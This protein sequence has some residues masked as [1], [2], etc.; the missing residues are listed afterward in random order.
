MAQPI[1]IPDVLA[2]LDA[3]LDLDREDHA[4]YE[5]G[6]KEPTSYAGLMKE[7]ARIRGLRRFIIPVPVLTAH[8]SSHWLNLVTPVYSRIGRRLIDSLTTPTVVR[9]E[10]A[11]RD[12]DVHPMGVREA[13]DQAR[14]EEEQENVETHWADALSSV[15]GRKHWGGVVFGNR[16]VDLRT[17][18]ID[19]PPAFAFAPIRKVGGR[20]G[21]PYANVLWHLRGLLDRLIGGVGMHRGRREP[22]WLR[23]GDALDCWRVEAFD[24]PWKLVLIAEMRMPGRAWLQFENTRE[25]GGV[26]ISQTAIFD[27]AGVGG[28][29]YWYALWP[30]HEF[31]F[32]G[33]LRNLARQAVREYE[34]EQG[35]N[36]HRHT[37]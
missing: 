13:I 28:V 4:I 15:G 5:I 6:G 22:D 24:P 9:D 20:N 14:Y 8:F 35:G 1:A 27:P 16:L 26:R 29:V 25:D 21:W 36:A 32:S 31:V 30:F 12:F 18:H 7:Y 23:V 10:A 19:V 3:A 2:Y 33:M 34:S 11:L 17:V 37:A